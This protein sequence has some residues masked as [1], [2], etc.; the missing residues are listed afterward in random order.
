MN[1]LAMFRS[2]CCQLNQVIVFIIVIYDYQFI[3]KNLSV[4]LFSICDA[5]YTYA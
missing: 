3:A 5:S 2:Q 4:M 1:V